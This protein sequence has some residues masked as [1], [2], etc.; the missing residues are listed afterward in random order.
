MPGASAHAIA[1]AG[2]LTALPTDKRS[3]M[4]ECARAAHPAR[5]LSCETSHAEPGFVAARIEPEQSSPWACVIAFTRTQLQSVAFAHCCLAQVVALLRAR[6]FAAAPRGQFREQAVGR[7]RGDRCLGR[8]SDSLAQRPSLAVGATCSRRL[9]TR[10]A[11]PA[12]SR[13]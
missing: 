12:R 9:L 3:T 10:R 2:D 1:P 7:P 11:D 6:V 13:S 8:R 5:S 4:K